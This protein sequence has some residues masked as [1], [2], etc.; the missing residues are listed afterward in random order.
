MVADSDDAI[1]DEMK[2]NI[3]HSD[4]E[5]RRLDQLSHPGKQGINNCINSLTI[6]QLKSD[7]QERNLTVNG[8]K[9][10]LVQCLWENIGAE[11]S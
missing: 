6:K 9:E 7:L 11:H 4:E 2:C 8:N 5:L 10:E 3:F 1:I